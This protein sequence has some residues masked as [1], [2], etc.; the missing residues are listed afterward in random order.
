MPGSP[1]ASTAKAYGG[2]EVP[3]LP[4]RVNPRRPGQDKMS[5]NALRRSPACGTGSSP[6]GTQSPH[7]V[8]VTCCMPQSITKREEAHREIVETG[9]KKN[10]KKPFGDKAEQVEV[11]DFVEFGDV[12]RNSRQQT[13]RLALW[14]IGTN[15][16]QTSGGEPR[17]R[18]G[19]SHGPRSQPSCIS[20]TTIRCL[21][22][23]FNAA[24]VA[25]Q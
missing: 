16:L 23:S 20:S 11:T 7:T 19:L 18:D 6:A 15:Q 2:Q 10:G 24:N 12:V 25:L 17:I 22:A 14:G 4:H 1:S 21:S 8:N 13:G 5:R 9:M 3:S